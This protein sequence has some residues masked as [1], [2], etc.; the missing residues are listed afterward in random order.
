MLKQMR[1]DKK[2]TQ[3]NLRLKLGISSGYMS[4]LETCPSTCNPTFDLIFNLE[5]ELNIEH[6]IVYLYFVESRQKNNP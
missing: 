4:E 5:K 1:K 3:L 6:G 2:I